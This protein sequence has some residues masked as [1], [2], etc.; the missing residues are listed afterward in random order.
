M[1]RAVCP[2]CWLPRHADPPEASIGSFP[3]PPL[4]WNTLDRE[5]FG[6]RMPMKSKG[7][8]FSEKMATCNSPLLK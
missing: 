1:W 7:F 6:P 8:R 2:D 4:N 3:Q 5:I